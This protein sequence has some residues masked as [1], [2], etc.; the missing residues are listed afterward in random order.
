[1]TQ[2]LNGFVDYLC[3]IPCDQDECMCGATGGHKIGTFTLIPCRIII[4]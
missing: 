2:R 3:F 1:M 4:K